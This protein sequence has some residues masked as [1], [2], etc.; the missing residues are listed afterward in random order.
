MSTPAGYSDTIQIEELE[1]S[2]RVGVPDEERAQAQRL[3]LSLT[4]WPETDFDL[5]DDQLARAV[6]YAAVCRDVKDLV[7]GRADKLIETLAAAIAAHLLAVHRIV[8][9]RVEL[10]KFILPEVKYVAVIMTRERG[11]A[12]SSRDRV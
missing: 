1:L 8:R 9:V 6:D 5:L 2:A 4:L 7:A 10:R 12:S 11:A 3:T